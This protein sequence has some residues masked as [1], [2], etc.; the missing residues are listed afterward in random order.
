MH[1][2]VNKVCQPH[3]FISGYI[4]I[5]QLKTPQHRSLVNEKPMLQKL[6]SV[7]YCVTGKNKYHMICL[8]GTIS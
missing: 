4:Y 6:W 2:G 7:R 1:Q 3:F 8:V 5:T